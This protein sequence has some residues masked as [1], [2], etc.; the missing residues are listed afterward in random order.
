MLGQS[1]RFDLGGA[2]ANLAVPSD[3]GL[4]GII[5][6]LQWY[7]QS[8]SDPQEVAVSDVFAT[9]IW[10]AP[11]SEAL[12][13][14]GA[15]SAPSPSSSGSTLGGGAAS[16]RTQH[17]KSCFQPTIDQRNNAGASV[18]FHAVRLLVAQ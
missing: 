6:L 7:I 5:V 14:G 4:E 8:A 3:P 9:R 16:N 17:A 10:S 2:F 12:G 18:R 13:G 1:Q 11:G 15:F